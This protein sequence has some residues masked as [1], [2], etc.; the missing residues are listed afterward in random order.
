MT[1]GSLVNNPASVSSHAQAD[2]QG[3]RV[4]QVTQHDCCIPPP[5]AQQV[6]SARP[7]YLV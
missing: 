1:A 4:S 6:D 7:D 3:A 2:V 5:D